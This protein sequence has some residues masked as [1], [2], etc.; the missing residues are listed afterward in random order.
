M[1]V[2][3]G[4]TLPTPLL[5]LYRKHEE[6]CWIQPKSW[7]LSCGV[8]ACCFSWLMGRKR[9][10]LIKTHQWWKLSDSFS[11]SV[12][13]SLSWLQMK[14]GATTLLTRVS[15]LNNLNWWDDTSSSQPAFVYY[16]KIT[17]TQAAQ[18]AAHQGGH[19]SHSWLQ[20]NF[21]LWWQWPSHTWSMEPTFSCHAASKAH[22]TRGRDERRRDIKVGFSD[23]GLWSAR[24]QAG[25][26]LLARRE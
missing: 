14:F 20:S 21:F 9:L 5:G 19:S 15:G 1:A 8:I 18:L 12:Y 25:P 3:N 22:N 17:R 16:L 11:P 6:S 10:A 2:I 7:A 24:F 23:L 4:L 13:L 26:S